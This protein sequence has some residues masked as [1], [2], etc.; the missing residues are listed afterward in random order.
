MRDKY[1][2][3][4]RIGGIS[5]SN[6]Q[7]LT[8]LHRG[9]SGPFTV[10]EA[11]AKMGITD[12][13]AARL[14]VAWAS[15]GWLSRIRRGLY[16]TVPLGARNPSAR[17]EDPWVVGMRVF[18][19]AYIG[20]WSACEHWDFT[21][22]ISADVLVFTTRNIRTRKQTVQDTTFIVRV[23]PKD[24]IWGTTQVWRGQTTI[25]VSDPVRTVID[26]LKEPRLGGGIRHCAEILESY[27]RS[28]HR[29][30]D[31]LIRYL[32]QLKSGTICKRLGF[33]IETMEIEALEVRE[34]CE[35]HISAGYSKLDPS[36][37]SSGQFRR[38]WN[39]EVNVQLDLE[40]SW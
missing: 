22:Q 13:R 24:R 10:S 4:N 11:A 18:S 14:L 26:I 5:E 3:S 38:R 12:D 15:Q 40:A 36:V 35:S 27:F 1:I 2:N 9:E 34:Y 16:I 25:V 6:R 20:G 23:V 29:A 37:K 8:Q 33:L 28:E 30:D 21:E 32:T 7:L 19:T 17:R 39:L 31:Q